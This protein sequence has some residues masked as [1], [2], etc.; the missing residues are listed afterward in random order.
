MGEGSRGSTRPPWYANK[1]AV[2]L[3]AR[4]EDNLGALWPQV[5]VLPPGGLYVGARRRGRQ[6]QK[7]P[8]GETVGLE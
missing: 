7:A 3:G 6:E 4:L 2:S 1:P 5:R 8:E